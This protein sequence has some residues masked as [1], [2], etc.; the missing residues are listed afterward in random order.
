MART[1]VL[2]YVF[3]VAPNLTWGIAWTISCY[4]RV[5]MVATH[6]WPGNRVNKIV[7]YNFKSNIQ[8]V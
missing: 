8:W 1:P 7:A 5:E 3:I 6:S 4:P 2:V